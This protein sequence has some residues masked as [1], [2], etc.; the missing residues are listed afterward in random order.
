MGML[1]S[2]IRYHWWPKQVRRQRQHGENQVFVVAG[3][4]CTAKKDEM[5]KQVSKM[6]NNKPETDAVLTVRE[7]G[8]LIELRGVA[9]RDVHDSFM[10]IPELVYDNPFGE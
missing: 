9:K 8:Q 10:R 6:T 5:A 1:S 3:V 4:P 7:H 2:V